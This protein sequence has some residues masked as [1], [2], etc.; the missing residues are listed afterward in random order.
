ML[1]KVVHQNSQKIMNFITIQ[2]IV[3]RM[4]T[5]DWLFTIPFKLTNSKWWKKCWFKRWMKMDN[6]SLEIWL[7]MHRITV[8]SQCIPAKLISRRFEK[9]EFFR[10]SHKMDI[11][12]SVMWQ[13]IVWW[14]CSDTYNR[15]WLHRW[16][17][18]WWLP[19]IERIGQK[20]L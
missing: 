1:I 6:V 16:V 19:Q 10:I 4:K 2:I 9:Q 18:P 15:N 7:A 11:I 3:Y 12:S 5:C 14:C 17:S 8:D 13:T 20:T